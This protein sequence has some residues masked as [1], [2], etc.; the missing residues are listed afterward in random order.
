[1]A[2]MQFDR[3]DTALIGAVVVASAVMAGAGSFELF[4]VALSDQAQIAG[5]TVSVAYVI[6]AGSLVFTV[7]TNEFG[8]IR[9]VQ[10]QAKENLDQTYYPMLLATF[11]LLFAWP[12]VPEIQTFVQSQDLWK[13]GFI[14]IQ[15]GGQIGIGYIK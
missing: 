4:N 3:E 1:M 14:S 5:A 12:F 10:E 2:E 9:D 11:G 13:V 8:G 6:T 7:V 15:T